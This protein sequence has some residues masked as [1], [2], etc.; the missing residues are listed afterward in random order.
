MFVLP[1]PIPGVTVLQQALRPSNNKTAK[2]FSIRAPTWIRLRYHFFS[3]HPIDFQSNS[4]LH[5]H[6]TSINLHPALE[7]P[8]QRN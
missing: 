4:P 6:R 3:R 8:A 7:R 5:A 2:T 1:Q